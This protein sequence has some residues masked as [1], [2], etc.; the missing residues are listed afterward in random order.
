M[1]A[2]VPEQE[3]IW[4]RFAGICRAN[5]V[6]DRD[7]D[8]TS[9]NGALALGYD[10]FGQRENKSWMRVELEGGYRSIL[11]GS[12]GKTTA[13]FTDGEDFTL[14]PEKR[15]SGWLGGLRVLG[16]DNGL[17]LAGEVNAEDR[18]DK[19]SVGGRFSVQLA[20]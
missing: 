6:D 15:K 16:G 14:T 17:V 12:L 7:S 10:L 11:S 9:V 18:G 1:D 8:E 2:S 4:P 20:L 19:V 3:N 5:H 13:H